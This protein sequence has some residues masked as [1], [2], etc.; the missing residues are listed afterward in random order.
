MSLRIRPESHDDAGEIRALTAAAFA[1]AP[2]AGGQEHRI[3][4]RLRETG[5][6]AISLV[7]QVDERVVGHVAISPVA[8]S[9]GSPGWYALGPIAVLP[10]RQSRGIGSALVRAALAHLRDRRAAGCVLVGDPAYYGRFGFTQAAPLEYP[11]VP[12]EYLQAVVFRRPVP[13][14]VVSF[15]QA[16][17]SG[18]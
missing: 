12:A 6:L 2:H 14:A 3:V 4:D 13:T 1:G 7:A 11:A 8:L 10:A 17:D 15:D 18:A 16:F 9:D 5:Q